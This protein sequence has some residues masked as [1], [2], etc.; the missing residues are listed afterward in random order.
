MADMP[1][2]P[3]TKRPRSEKQK[4]NDERLRK[5][6]SEIRGN[7]GA[8]SPDKMVSEEP[9]GEHPKVV[10]NARTPAPTRRPHVSTPDSEVSDPEIRGG[11]SKSERGN[12]RPRKDNSTDAPSE[13]DSKGKRA[14]GNADQG[15]DSPE[16]DPDTSH[17]I[18]LF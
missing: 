12:A 4:A 17:G 15:A 1:P 6:W 8:K 11:G 3:P 5:Y 7:S 14:K 10:P 13:S 16:S 18:M 2:D 9:K